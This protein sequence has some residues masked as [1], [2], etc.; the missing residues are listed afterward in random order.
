MSAGH[1]DLILHHRPI[2]YRRTYDLIV[3]LVQCR[4][5]ELEML[6]YKNYALRHYNP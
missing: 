5:Q 3:L 4:A 2:A 6:R 1:E